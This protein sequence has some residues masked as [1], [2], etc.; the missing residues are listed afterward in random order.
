MCH[1][2]GSQLLFLVQFSFYA[3]LLLHLLLNIVTFSFFKCLIICILVLTSLVLEKH[4]DLKT[5]EA[6]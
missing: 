1:S 5:A 3:L 4:L 6:L 2:R